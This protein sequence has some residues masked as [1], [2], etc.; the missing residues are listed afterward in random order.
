MIARFTRDTGTPCGDS[1]STLPHVLL[2]L[3]HVSD[4]AGEH[5]G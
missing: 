2:D 1:T 3:E 5:I 4:Y